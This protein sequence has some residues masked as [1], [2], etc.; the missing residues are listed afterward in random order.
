[1][2]QRIFMGGV[3]ISLLI[4]TS[5]QC[6]TEGRFVKD[7][8]LIN[9][10]LHLTTND[11]KVILTPKSDYSIEVEYQLLGIT[12]P[13]SYALLQQIDVVPTEFEESKNEIL[14]STKGLSVKIQKCP[15]KI[16]YY[17]HNKLLF[18]EE[19]GFVYNDSIKGFRMQLDSTELLMGGGE[20]VLGMNRRGQKLRLY[21][22]ASYGYGTKAELMYYSLPIVISSNKYM[23]LFDNTADGYLDLGKTEEDILQFETV[24][25][26]MSYV[27]TASDNWQGL[28][29][30]Y[31]AITGYQP[32]PPRWALGNISSRMGYRSQKQVEDVV[33][34]YQKEDFP[35]D[36]MVLDLYWFGPDLQ[37]H[38]GNLEW[39]KNAFPEPEK[40]MANIKDKG[41]KTVLITEPFILKNSGKYKECAT[42][43]L[44]GTDSIGNPY[45]YD[46]YFGTTALLDIF[47]PETKSWF[48]DVYKK[49]SLSG[50][51][52]WWGDLGEP[53]VHP[54]ELQHVNGAA[55][56][57]HNAYGHEWARTVFEGYEQDFND[58]RPVILMRA[59]YAG[60]QRYGLIPWSGDVARSWEGLQPQVEISL[61]MGMQGLAYMHSDL[62]GFAGDYK[63]AELYTRWLQYGVFQP[64]YR[65]HAQEDVPPEPIFWDK[66]T[67]DITRRYIKLRY[68]LTPYLYTLSYFNSTQGTP[69][70]RPLFY[71]DDNPELLEERNSYLWGE[72]FLVAPVTEKSATE[73]SVNFPAGS[74][75]YN[76]FTGEKISGGQVK[77]VPVDI[78]NIPV[79]VKGGSF[80]PMVPE[81]NNMEEYNTEELFVHYYHD[82]TVTSSQ[83]MMYEDDG[84]TNNSW[85]NNQFEKLHFSS[86]NSS[87]ALSIIIKRDGYDYSGKPASRE[88]TLVIHQFEDE[89][90]LVSI[91]NKE[92]S[93][94]WNSDK[95]ELTATF[96]M[97]TNALKI[98]I[99]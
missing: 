42:Q 21:N 1:M 4:L 83:S 34:L 14:Y 2:L 74:N 18:E 40:M 52:G 91:N 10:A 49:H 95:Q 81:F 35:L 32:M 30:N 86:L 94:N 82:K 68:A 31:T 51:D 33:S 12:N 28:T 25:G 17:K 66:Q 88:I 75:W 55:N 36:G 62:G 71:V 89:P 53:E 87:D 96:T 97:K 60:S 92:I 63:D 9:Q 6:K 38:M 85:K 67:K 45:I 39:D 41:V 79:F 98:D 61:Q 13:D 7:A 48:W 15:L 24:G 46:F 64:V 26:R 84:E 43:N 23:L 90:E 70:M 69:L 77:S 37:G 93:F 73:W 50:V 8:E 78:Y 72:N 59:G 29:D 27:V 76:Y 5:C 99:K 57:V 20:R 65:T 44:L 47:K 56:L 3:F 22:Q 80:I 19:Q 11:A 54:D 58:K 16:S